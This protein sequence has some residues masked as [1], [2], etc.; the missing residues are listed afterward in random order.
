MPEQNIAECYRTTAVIACGIGT[1]A[2]PPADVLAAF[3]CVPDSSTRPQPRT[4]D[5]SSPVTGCPAS[6]SP[7]LQA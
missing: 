4:P 2:I 3:R 7:F 1:V 5:S 6:Y